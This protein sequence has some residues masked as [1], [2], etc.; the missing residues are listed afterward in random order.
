MHLFSRL[1]KEK[2][3]TLSK[4]D[5]R[6]ENLDVL[7]VKI[8][9]DFFK[10]RLQ[11]EEKRGDANRPISITNIATIRLFENKVDVVYDPS[12]VE[13]DEPKF[14]GLINRK[15]NW[16]ADNKNAV[17]REIAGELLSLKNDHWLD[18]HETEIT[19][20]EFI[21]RMRLTRILFFRDKSSELIFADGDLFWGH[22]IV[23]NL[24]AG[25]KLT[26]VNISG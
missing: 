5:F 17:R 20:G 16:I 19:K 25:N 7:S 11:T 14:I 6:T 10:S 9:G 26:Y 12:E 22:Q 1:K 15:L 23:A 2:E 3:F 18:E 21:R 13:L 24:N 4:S 8:S